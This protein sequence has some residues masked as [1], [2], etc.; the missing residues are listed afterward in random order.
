VLKELE[1]NEGNKERKQAMRELNNE[2]NGYLKFDANDL[3]GQ[4]NNAFEG[5]PKIAPEKK[6][7]SKEQRLKAIMSEAA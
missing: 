2:I 1:K 4:M 7:K 5:K 3:M 6:N